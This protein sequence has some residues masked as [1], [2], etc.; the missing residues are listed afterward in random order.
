MVPSQRR[1]KHRQN[2]ARQ[3]SLSSAIVS[4]ALPSAPVVLEES[5]VE[6]SNLA[7][8]VRKPITN[9]K[10]KVT[11]PMLPQ[12]CDQKRETRKGV[13]AEKTKMEEEN[14]EKRRP[15]ER[16]EKRKRNRKTE[17]KLHIDPTKKKCT[18]RENVQE[19]I[20]SLGSTSVRTGG[21]VV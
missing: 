8:K 18:K 15:K 11:D 6:D 21:D 2:L 10:S 13:G 7:K 17:S 3:Q 12:V 1:K 16:K 4:G 14:E 9:I 19:Q 5:I 20:Q